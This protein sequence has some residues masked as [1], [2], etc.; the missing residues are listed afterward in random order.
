[1]T[2]HFR[3]HLKIVNL[4]AAHLVHVH[5]VAGGIERVGIE[6]LAEESGCAAFA[7]H[8]TLLQWTRQHHEGEHRFFLWFEADDVRAKVW[9][10]LRAGW[11][12]LTGRA[13][14]VSG[15]TSHHLVDC[16]GVIEQAVGRVAHRTHHGKFVVH[17]SQIR[18]E[19]GEIDPGQLGLDGLKD[20]ADVGRRVG[21]GVPEVDVAWAA[22]QVE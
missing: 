2:E 9:E 4:D 10:I 15:V 6:R 22:L 12:Q 18:Q 1:M 14:L 11:F 16:G 7:D 21:L 8:V 17:L 3:A 19:L 20:G 13:H 5:V